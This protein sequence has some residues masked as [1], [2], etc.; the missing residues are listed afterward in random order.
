MRHNPCA[1]IGMLKM[2]YV[3]EMYYKKVVHTFKNWRRQNSCR[4]SLN[5]LFLYF[6]NEVY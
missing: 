5:A 4:E 2:Y 3:F 6:T 1:Y